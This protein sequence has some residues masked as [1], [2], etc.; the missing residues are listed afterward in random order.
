MKR[1]PGKMVDPKKRGGMRRR[2][3][4]K[5]VKE[6]PGSSQIRLAKIVYGEEGALDGYK[7]LRAHLKLLEDA[8]IIEIKNGKERRV[9]LTTKGKDFYE[10]EGIAFLSKNVREFIRV[11]NSW[12]LT[13]PL[14]QEEKIQVYGFLDD[15]VLESL[16]AISDILPLPVPD[17]MKEGYLKL[18]PAIDVWRCLK[19]LWIYYEQ[20][21]E[22]EGY[23]GYKKF[24]VRLAESENLTQKF[25]DLNAFF[26]KLA[27]KNPMLAELRDYVIIKYRESP[28][29]GGV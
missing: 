23:G 16:F 28:L 20:L 18:K 27:L 2:Q 24:G 22:S 7:S 29:A 14:T 5:S 17:D 4:L 12:L 10:S 1:D 13:N 26:G 3:I 6:N 9:Y 19:G 8:G 11:L 25:L 21:G 15:Q